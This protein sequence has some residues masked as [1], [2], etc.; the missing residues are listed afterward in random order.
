MEFSVSWFSSTP[1]AIGLTLTLR[2]LIYTPFHLVNLN[3]KNAKE[4]D[5]NSS[6]LDICLKVGISC[7]VISLWWGEIRIFNNPPSAPY[8]YSVYEWQISVYST[9]RRV[10]RISVIQ[11]I[12]GS[13]CCEIGTPGPKTVLIINIFFHSF[14]ILFIHLLIL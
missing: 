3:N 11:P 7:T 14:I 4:I 6:I 12:N 9:I 1:A 13:I 5:Q 10:W 2:E 8:I